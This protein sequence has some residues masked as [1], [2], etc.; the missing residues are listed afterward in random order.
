MKPVVRRPRLALTLLAVVAAIA[1]LGL[2][3]VR[4]PVLR[5]V[6]WALVAEDP[7]QQADVIVTTAAGGTAS[8]LEAAD[9]VHEG[10]AK[11][12]AVFAD[13]PE[14]ADREMMRRGLP[15]G[16]N[17]AASLRQLRLLG[18][19]AV[20]RIPKSVAGSEEEARVL[21]AWCRE[22]QVRSVVLI[23]TTDHSR[24]LH[25]LFRRTM[26]GGGTTVAVRGTRYSAF[27]PDRWWQTRDGARTG[28]VELQK[29]LLDLALHPLS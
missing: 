5:S 14:D 11:R 8:I 24:R 7:L 25:R 17:A 23:S 26:Q 21:P 2:P 12:V 18:I 29:L 15:V 27:K 22:R 28:I 9:L 13:P 10:I 3:A 19:E 6:G 4:T 1:T 16:D 20:E